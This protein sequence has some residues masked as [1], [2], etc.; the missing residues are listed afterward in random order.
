MRSVVSRS[1]PSPLWN[2]RL[3]RTPPCRS[4]PRPR[5]PRCCSRLCLSCPL[6]RRRCPPRHRRLGR[7]PPCPRCRRRSPPCP[8]CPRCRGRRPPSPRCPRCRGRRS[9]SPRWHRRLRRQRRR[10]RACSLAT[11]LQ[12]A[13]PCGKKSG[14]NKCI[15]YGAN[16]FRRFEKLEMRVHQTCST[17]WVVE[18][19]AKSFTERFACFSNQQ[20]ERQQVLVRTL[21]MLLKPSEV[22]T[23]HFVG[24]IL[25]AS[26]T[27]IRAYN[28]PLIRNNK[29][30]SVNVLRD[31]QT[32]RKVDK[33]LA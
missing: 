8:R 9:P 20:K 33:K 18:G 27:I 1:G 12:A 10:G 7:R 15:K 5:S 29:N 14:S 23:K 17:V 32:T 16:Y 19:N 21:R 22:S 13:S 24:N 3:A 2:P 4:T 31:S 6:C 26:H 30:C 28:P 25:Y 11:R